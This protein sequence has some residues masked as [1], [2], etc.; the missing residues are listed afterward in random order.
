MK[1]PS[2]IASLL[3]L[4]S[5]SSASPPLSNRFVID[6][7]NLSALLNEPP[8]F[9]SSAAQQD[10]PS[11]LSTDVVSIGSVTRMDYLTSQIETWASH[12]SIRHFWG[13]SEL[14]DYDQ[15]CS[16]MSD[17]A[18]AALVDACKD[19]AH[20]AFGDD[21]IQAFFEEYYGLSEGNVVRSN[22]AGWICA[23]RRVGR[24]FGWLHAQYFEGQVDVPDYL[25]VVDDDTYLD[26]VDVMAYL[27]REREKIDNNE[28]AF[29]RAGCV[30]QENDVIPFPLAYGGFGTILNKAAIQQLSEPIYCERGDGNESPRHE[31]ICSQIKLNKVGEAAIFQDGMTI[32][33]LFYKYAA[34]K[35]Y[36]MHSDWLFGY[37]LQYYLPSYSVDVATPAAT[38]GEQHHTLVGMKNY[39]AC[40]NLTVA[41]GDIRPC[42]RFSDAC[43]NQGPKEMESLALASFAKSPESYHAV[44]KMSSTNLDVARDI[45]QKKEY[46]SMVDGLQLPTIFLMG[47]SDAG[48]DEVAKWLFSNDGVCGPKMTADEDS[49]HF[50]NR[51]TKGIRFYAEHFAHCSGNEATIDSAPDAIM[52]AERV[53]DMYSQVN[54]ESLSKLKFIVIA[55]EFISNEYT[56][57]LK[58]WL[59]YFDRQQLLLLSSS[60]LQQHAERTQWRIEQFMGRNFDVALNSISTSSKSHSFQD[61]KQTNDA[62]LQFV[63]T[64]NGPWMEQRPFPRSDA[65][66]TFA[67]ATVLG[68]NPDKSQNKLYL[69]ATRVLIRS[70]KGSIADFVVLMMNDDKEAET[71]LQSEGAIIK[72]IVPINHS[73]ENSYFE[74]WFIDIALA[75]L[76]AFEL[77]EYKRVQVLDVDIAIKAA[78]MDTLFTS[79]QQARLVSEGLGSD[80][81]VRAGWF[82]L[83]PSVQ[84]FKDM[85]QLLEHGVFTNERGWDNL[86][87]PVDYPGWKLVNP[88]PKWEFYGSQLEQGLLFHHFYA[89]PK[90]LNPSAKD[91]ELLTLLDDD[92][93]LS[94]GF[95]HF[96]GD[97]KPWAGNKETSLLPSYVLTTRDLW[98]KGLQDLESSSWTEA[99]N[100]Q[101]A[102]PL[103]QTGYEQYR[104]ALVLY[105]ASPSA[106]PSKFPTTSPSMSP[107]A[108]VPT[109]PTKSPTRPS[110]APTKAPITSRPTVS[111]AA[112]AKTFKL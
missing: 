47:L 40:G 51:Y 100:V 2:A 50:E 96:Y 8:S 62:F 12:R 14:Q 94:L 81:P 66:K 13:F 37:V 42:T 7:S 16:A 98:L 49:S 23:Q 111:K 21:R 82:M 101:H 44:P 72:H 93:L 97:R 3:G 89:L 29:A 55:S 25:M 110:S 1:L 71:L 58:D 41:T 102:L 75:K 68:W 104:R 83:Y 105:S 78:Q 26:L 88:S 109:G 67:Y 107:L 74:P 34:L 87:L 17:E 92:T 15:E 22:D 27:E 33:Q 76:R 91:S 60:E 30:F 95:V 56:S 99:P 45:I 35:N 54:D 5:Q 106:S 11:S 10:A 53:H 86:D 69:D 39:P 63:D 59:R 43:H 4:V 90:S 36:C 38:Q 28:A 24:A 57:Y 64:E 73:L 48:S 31:T 6:E 18:R 112:K 46:E 108:S 65:L 19:R 9:V 77:T 70:V 103:T 20:P 52:Q 61:K 84:D 32:F 79:Y 85:E 80:S